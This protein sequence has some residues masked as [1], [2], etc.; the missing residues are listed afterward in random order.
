LSAVLGFT[1]NLENTITQYKNGIDM[2]LDWGA[3][4]FLTKEWQV[5]LVGYVYN[6]VSCDSG[7]GNRVG[8]FESRVFGV[9]PQIGHIFQIDEELQGYVNLKGY[10]E[11][12][13]EHRPSG[14]NV[15]ATFSVSPAPKKKSAEQKS[16]MQ[17]SAMQKSAGQKSAMQMSAAQMSA[18]QKSVEQKSAAQKAAEQK[19]AESKRK[20]AAKLPVKAPPPPAQVFTWSGFYF[21]PHLGGGRAE[22]KA[23]SVSGPGLG[24]FDPFLTDLNGSGVVGG[25]QVGFNWQFEPSWVIGLEGDISGA[26]IDRTENLS[27]ATLQGVPLAP[28]SSLTLTRNVNWLASVRGRIGYA[29]D[30]TLLYVTGGGAWA[31]IRLEGA[32]VRPVPLPRIF[33]VGIGD[34]QTGWVVG[35]GFEYAFEDSSWTIRG[36]FLHYQ[37]DGFSAESLPFNGFTA[38]DTLGN[39]DVNVGRVGFNYKLGEPPKVTARY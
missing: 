19:Q 21:G 6:Q 4:Q 39:F 18:E 1:Y 25:A 12:Q 2:H 29:W 16:T 26:Q 27:P 23:Q 35:G 11:F 24:F 36:E 28:F 22:G 10:G 30:R 34:T 37:F 9:G 38:R 15:W 33:V 7:S 14:W 17:K 31:N 8:C 20:A 5:G 13:S 32:L 3:S